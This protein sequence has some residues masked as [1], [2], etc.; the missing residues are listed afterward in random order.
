MT[1]FKFTTLVIIALLCVNCSSY[2][3]GHTDGGKP[4]AGE[5]ID[6]LLISLLHIDSGSLKKESSFL[7]NFNKQLIKDPLLHLKDSGSTGLCLKDSTNSRVT[8]LVN[9]N[10]GYLSYQW[11]QR[12]GIDTPF[13][14]TNSSQ[15]LIRASFSAVVADLL[16]VRV[17]YFERHSNSQIFQDFRDFKIEFD[18]NE[19]FNMQKTKAQKR[20]T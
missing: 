17:S 6:S 7:P 13:S 20:V 2:A 11:I 8:H 5:S 15:H 12:T 1:A 10:R 19:F 18:A 14:E 9:F 3:Q 4:L 16:P